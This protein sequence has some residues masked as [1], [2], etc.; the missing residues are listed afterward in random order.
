[1]RPGHLPT[2]GARE[3]LEAV[4][5]A[6]EAREKAERALIEALIEGQR[7]GW[8]LRELG[9]ASRL[10]SMTVRSRIAKGLASTHH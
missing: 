4:E 8:S 2:R 9:Q 1:M 10:S 3:A 5:A 7:W 6:A